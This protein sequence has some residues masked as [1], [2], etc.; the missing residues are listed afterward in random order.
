MKIVVT[1][2]TD[3]HTDYRDDEVTF[4]E[5][6]RDGYIE[7]NHEGSHFNVRKSELRK[8]LTLLCE[9]ETE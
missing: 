3:M 9:E 1:L 8:V 5:S 2:T 6:W 4:K 7:I